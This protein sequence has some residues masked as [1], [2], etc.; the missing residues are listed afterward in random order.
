MNIRH[1]DRAN[2]GFDKAARYSSMDNI[3]LGYNGA[4][5]DIIGRKLKKDNTY[6]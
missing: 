2:E 6:V 1:Y 3:V 5:A 4:M